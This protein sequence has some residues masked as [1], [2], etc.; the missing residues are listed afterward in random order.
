[1]NKLLRAALRMTKTH[2]MDGQLHMAK[3]I[4]NDEVRI[5]PLTPVI[6][7]DPG[8]SRPT[9]MNILQPA[10]HV[11]PGYC[12]NTISS[13]NLERIPDKRVLYNRDTRLVADRMDIHINEIAERVKEQG[14]VTFIT[15]N[16]GAMKYFFKSLDNVKKEFPFSSIVSHS[17]PSRGA[18]SKMP[19]DELTLQ[20]S[21]YDIQYLI[22]IFN[23]RRA[24][25]IGII[26]SLFWPRWSIHSNEFYIKDELVVVVNKTPDNLLFIDGQRQ[27]SEGF[28]E[29]AYTKH[30]MGI[31]SGESKNRSQIEK[32][33]RSE[34]KSVVELLEGALE[35]E[36]LED[37]TSKTTYQSILDHGHLSGLETIQDPEADS[38]PEETIE[39][40]PASGITASP[41]WGNYSLSANYVFESSTSTS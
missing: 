36:K 41:V 21:I 39:A 2:A 31:I 5:P 9:I 32:S 14:A 38:I 27:Y 37:F 20:V 30:Y 7:R 19:H 33:K 25:G 15:T 24:S 22:P 3:V 12:L 13:K 11:C 8:D 34:K 40:T 18:V 17:S 16:L 10:N 1:M 28:V 29:R 35:P 4:F 23:P 6:V 26:A